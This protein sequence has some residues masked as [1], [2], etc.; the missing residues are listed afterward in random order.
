M[1]SRLSYL[2]IAA[3]VFALVGCG[4]GPTLGDKN[5]SR[6]D[7]VPVPVDASQTDV[8]RPDASLP[9]IT[10]KDGKI[11][12]V[13]GK[14]I[15]MRGINLQYGAGT[16]EQL[17]G[18]TAIS[19]TGSNVIRLLVNTSTTDVQLEK[20]LVKS[21][22]KGLISIVSLSDDTLR[23]KEDVDALRSAVVNVWL[24]KW[25]TILAEDRFQSSLIINIAD[26]WGPVG[27]YYGD[28]T[29][30]YST[31][32]HKFRTA[33]FKV[34]LMIDA[35]DCGQNYR[36]FNLQTGEALQTTDSEH[37]V[38]LSVQADG[39]RWSSNDKIVS[40]TAQLEDTGVPYIISSLKGSGVGSP[41]AVDHKAVMD[42]AMG[43][44]ALQFN[45]PWVGVDA[46]AGYTINLNKTSNL[47]GGAAV[48][49]NVKFDADYLEIVGK[50]DKRFA[51][52]K[53]KIAIY[54]KDVN[55]NR[56]M[57]ASKLVQELRSVIWNS[58]SGSVPADADQVDAANL[59]NG[60]TTFDLEQVTEAG[61][62]VLAN[63]KPESVTGKIK[64][65]DLRVSEG[66]PP[67]YKAGFAETVEDWN[68]SSATSS[69]V[70]GSWAIQP[71]GG[72]VTIS[73][74]DS[75]NTIDFSKPLN[76]TIRIFVPA[77]YQA[78]INSAWIQMF[79]QFGAGWSWNAFHIDSSSFKPGEWTDVKVTIPF[80]E[81]VPA[82]DIKTV[83]AF[84]I[85]FGGMTAKS[86][87][88]LIDSIT[89]VDPSAKK[90]KAVVATQYKYTFPDTEGFVPMLED[91]SSGNWLGAGKVTVTAANGELLLAPTSAGTDG[92]VV[93]ETRDIYN[94][95][96]INLSGPLTIKTKVFV[97]A[98]YTGS[99]LT[100]HIY[101]QDGAWSGWFQTPDKTAESFVPGQWSDV[102][103]VINSFPSGYKTG[104]LPHSFGIQ[105]GGISDLVGSTIK[106]KDIEFVGTTY[107]D[108][109][110][111][112]LL[113]EFTNQAD[114]DL[115]K[116][117]F[118]VG[119]FTQSSL[120]NAKSWTY[121]V[122]PFGWL[123][124]SW[125]GNAAS[126]AALDLSLSEDVKD[127]KNV[128]FVL[129]P[130]GAEIILGANGIQE[131]SV[132]ATFPPALK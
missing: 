52:G 63:G 34:P 112:A 41:A 13:N 54:I 106:I 93:V 104:L 119:G 9:V 37:N 31:Y 43:N 82:S 88:I 94:I 10:T 129:T 108:D 81:S 61:V 58:I 110:T 56:L 86:S 117:D 126:A 44:H 35:P 96:E 47:K 51:T 62:V 59:M 73:L 70:N 40:A 23:C 53:T 100:M 115:V 28:Y 15:L 60:A 98:S 121:K 111:P 83:Q 95:S 3:S 130:R 11:Y 24:K 92:Y 113:A 79:A 68:V 118:G 22:E 91:L 85:Q 21:L 29:A 64:F 75:R 77:E 2:A 123:A 125:R 80:G 87:P 89:I 128:S 109:S 78:D 120:I 27:S 8:A 99:T 65:D 55:G 46:G 33:G 48:S 107:V 76:A 67:M 127:P 72:D 1:K 5:K 50:G 97:P 19:A 84:G 131:T 39:S 30:E 132:L 101:L 116:F 16:T 105:F 49:V 42:F 90:M 57:L 20:A 45:F 14:P 32:I 25:L 17:D 74:G 36:A 102:N 7:L 6:D 38:I 69:V 66:I 26:G 18:V 12:D 122:S 4:G 114:L 103:F 71:T 124:H